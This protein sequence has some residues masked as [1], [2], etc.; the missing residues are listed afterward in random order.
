[1]KGYIGVLK[2]PKDDD[3]EDASDDEEDVSDDEN[4]LYEVWI[5]D[6]RERVV[7]EKEYLTTETENEHLKE[8]ND[9]LKAEITALK[10]QLQAADAN[11]EKRLEQLG[12]LEE[13]KVLTRA[14]HRNPELVEKELELLADTLTSLLETMDTTNTEFQQKIVDHCHRVR[15]LIDEGRG[16]QTSP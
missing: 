14:H 10:G 11:N 1:M 16:E 6:G 2:Y 15:R 13:A 3:E 12:A 7:I 9:A 8:K 4:E 5:G